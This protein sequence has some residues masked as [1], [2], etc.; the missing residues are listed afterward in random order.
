VDELEV[1]KRE[2]DL[3]ELAQNFGYQ[4]VK[5]E[6]S[7]HCK[8]MQSVR[9]KLVIATDTKDGHGIYFRVG[10]DQ[11]SG[12]VIDFVQGR[13]GG[14]LG[15]T[16]KWLRSYLG[17]PRCFP[18]NGLTRPAA[19]TS[20]NARELTNLHAQWTAMP[21]YV[22]PYLRGRGIHDDVVQ[23]FG[24]RQDVRGNACMSHV[25]P[26][27]E[28]SGWE[29]KNQG[30]TGFVA[31]GVK[32]LGL[33][34]PKGKD[35]Q[36]VIVVEAA[37]DAMSYAQLRGQ[38][39]DMYVSTA[40]SLGHAQCDQ[41]AILITRHRLA[42]LVLGTDADNGGD[43]MAARLFQIAPAAQKVTR[44]RPPAKDWNEVLQRELARL[45]AGRKDD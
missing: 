19:T 35:V 5:A 12:S 27:G 22:G 45:G 4:L 1:F 11:D 8:V 14:N 36:R 24:V 18:A 40:G 29:V 16:R 37:I 38:F 7:Q 9:D 3:V 15:Q 41:L 30:F 2:I 34:W 25:T 33:V 13:L 17:T 44:D 39:A 6:S 20:P 23:A 32:G 10:H 21:P 43:A 42:E 28:I 26:D 31:G